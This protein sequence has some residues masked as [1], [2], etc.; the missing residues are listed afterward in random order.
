MHNCS[1]THLPPSTVIFRYRGEI[2]ESSNVPRESWRPIWTRVWV[3]VLRDRSVTTI[4]NYREQ[5]Y[6]LDSPSFIERVAGRR[7]LR[8]FAHCESSTRV[9]PALTIPRFYLVRTGDPWSKEA[10]DKFILWQIHRCDTIALSLS[11]C[12]LFQHAAWSVSKRAITRTNNAKLHWGGNARFIALQ[13]R[14]TNIAMR[15]RAR[16]LYFNSS[17]PPPFVARC[18]RMSGTGNRYWWLA[19]GMRSSECESNLITLIDGKKRRIYLL[20]SPVLGFSDS[21]DPR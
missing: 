21:N 15:S 16:Y 1:P 18:L 4:I 14:L 5:N 8:N 10:S 11:L 20:L 12:R 17:N 2:R 13:R 19:R 3:T 6:P 7:L 9:T